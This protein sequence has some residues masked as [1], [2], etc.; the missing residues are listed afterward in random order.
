MILASLSPRRK[1]L[2]SL[3]GKPFSIETK[4]I[5]EK[6][7]P[8]LSPK[9]NVKALAFEKAEAVAK[10]QPEEVVIG[11]DTIVCLK[12]EIMGKP[13][14]ADEAKEML[15]ALSG[16]SHEVYTGVAILVKGRGIKHVF[17]DKTKVYMKELLETEIEAYVAT[18]EPLDKAGSYGIQGQG[19]LYIE[20]IEGDYYNVMGLPVHRVYEILRLMEEGKNGEA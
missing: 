13:K 16:Q 5:E 7:N 8:N 1:E 11:A 9:E 17:A 14:N 18:K 12:G 3:I 10:E 2:L 15:R 19:A 20:G 6:I 4:N